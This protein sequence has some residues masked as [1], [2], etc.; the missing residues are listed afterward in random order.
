M[1]ALKVSRQRLVRKSARFDPHARLA[2]CS[3]WNRHAPPHPAAVTVLLGSHEKVAPHSLSE[4]TASQQA[5]HHAD[6]QFAGPKHLRSS[7]V[8]QAA[9][10]VSLLPPAPTGESNPPEDALLPVELIYDVSRPGPESHHPLLAA[11]PASET[12][13]EGLD[14]NPE[15]SHRHGAIKNA[16]NPHKAKGD[17][18]SHR[19]ERSI[20][21]KRFFPISRLGMQ[22][23][24]ELAGKSGQI[25][26][27]QVVKTREV[28]VLFHK[29]DKSRMKNP[30][31]KLKIRLT[32]KGS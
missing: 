13:S 29:L 24:R 16:S 8:S 23:R 3:L 14:A 7:L 32:V 1:A 20:L 12:S 22:N 21:N 10:D 11:A 17:D 28:S 2:P 6:G 31:N 18:I 26:A 5:L 19:H 15:I 4:H 27:V 30:K 9:F 25:A